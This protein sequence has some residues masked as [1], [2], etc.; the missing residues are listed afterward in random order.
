MGAAGGVDVMIARPPAELGGIDPTLHLERATL[1]GVGADRELLRLRHGLRS[2]REFDRVVAVGQFE[3]FAVSA[4]DLRMEGEIGRE[5]FRLRR[6]NPALGIADDERR[7]RRADRFHPA[8][9]A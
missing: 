4:V 9:G 2:A 1:L 6:V 5:P 8:R 7:G 3:R